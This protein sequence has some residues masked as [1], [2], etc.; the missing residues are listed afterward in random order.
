MTDD[1]K[2]LA[3]VFR[4][5]QEAAIAEQ[6]TREQVQWDLAVATTEADNLMKMAHAQRTEAQARLWRALAFLVT[7]ATLAGIIALPDLLG[8]WA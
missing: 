2:P 4:L 7:I 1:D 6:R 5:D 8:W 3:D